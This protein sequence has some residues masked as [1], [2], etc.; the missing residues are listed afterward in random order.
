VGGEEGGEG[1]REEGREE[2]REVKYAFF[3]CFYRLKTRKERTQ[4][5]QGPARAQV[6]RE[7]DLLEHGVVVEDDGHH[8]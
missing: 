8:A 3:V 7:G 6:K 4:R 1:G 5:R 2:G